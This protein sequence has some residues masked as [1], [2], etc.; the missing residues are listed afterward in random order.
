LSHPSTPADA[1]PSFGK[2]VAELDDVMSAMAQQANEQNTGIRLGASESKRQ[3]AL[4]EALWNDYMTPIAGVARAIYGV[5]GV[6]EALK[7]P[8]KSADNDRLLEAA[9]GMANAAAADKAVFL[10]HGLKDD[11][12]DQLRVATKALREALLAR[13]ETGRRRVTATIG[14]QEQVKRGARAVHALNA[15][16]RPTLRRNPDLNAAWENAKARSEPS[17]GGGVTSLPPAPTQAQPPATDAA[18]A[19]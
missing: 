16:L 5:P 4:R 2:K 11:F 8:R 17:G 14:V 1:P 15:I 10:E 6:K 18:Q 9:D 13:I 12:V 3:A 7:L 19:A